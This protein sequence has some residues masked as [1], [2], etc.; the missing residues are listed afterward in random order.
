M[1]K[2]ATFLGFLTKNIAFSMK[3]NF[4]QKV[5]IIRGAYCSLPCEFSNDNSF[6]PKSYFEFSS[7]K[8]LCSIIDFKHISEIL[9]FISSAQTFPSILWT[10]ICQ[11]RSCGDD[12][13]VLS[14]HLGRVSLSISITVLQYCTKVVQTYFAEI[15]DSSWLF[16][17]K[18]SNSR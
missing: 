5:M 18:I 7:K 17:E 13:F 6:G 16:N 2:F 8:L 3:S 14:S 4:Q 15:H 12:S 1:P 9:L 10:T 11:V